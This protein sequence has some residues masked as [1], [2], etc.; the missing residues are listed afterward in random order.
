M[1]NDRISPFEEV[2]RAINN[3]NVLHTQTSTITT[4]HS[5]TVKKLADEYPNLGLTLSPEEA[6]KQLEK[7]QKESLCIVTTNNG[8]TH[9]LFSHEQVWEKYKALEAAHK[10]LSLQQ[11]AQIINEELTRP[12]EE[13]RQ[14]IL[15]NTI[16]F[17]LMNHIP[18]PQTHSFKT[19]SITS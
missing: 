5:D 2:V 19:Q 4:P 7:R 8:K 18:K 10:E 14:A 3:H 12:L 9:I 15:Y 11:K 1:S 17:Q 6:F 13:L 16:N